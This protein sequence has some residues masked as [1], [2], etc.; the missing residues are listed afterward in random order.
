MLIGCPFMNSISLAMLSLT[1]GCTPKKSELP[2]PSWY[3]PDTYE[4]SSGERC[5]SGYHEFS[6]NLNL[7]K[8]SSAQRARRKLSTTLAEAMTPYVELVQQNLNIS[9]TDVQWNPTAPD[10]AIF[11]LPFASE[12][13]TVELLPSPQT[14]QVLWSEVCVTS[15]LKDL[16]VTLNSRLIAEHQ[17]SYT[18][19]DVDMKIT[20]DEILPTFEE[21]LQ[22]LM[23][24]YL[25]Q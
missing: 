24:T 9:V 14:P 7:S 10:D 22:L 1:I 4:N 13:R 3:H 16:I 17:Q 6:G 2:K 25:S 11:N 18:E 21:K 5:A 19:D 20:P 8:S 23:T 15:E 12:V